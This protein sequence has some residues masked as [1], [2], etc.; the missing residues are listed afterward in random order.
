MTQRG[1][2]IYVLPRTD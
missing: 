2:Q 1:W